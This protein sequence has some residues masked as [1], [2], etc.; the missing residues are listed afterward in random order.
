MKDISPKCTDA[1]LEATAPVLVYT[2]SLGRN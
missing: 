1:M 2:V